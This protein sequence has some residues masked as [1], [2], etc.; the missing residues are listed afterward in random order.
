MPKRKVTITFDEDGEPQINDC[1]TS[2]YGDSNGRS[3]YVSINKKY[4]LK[5]DDRGFHHDDEGV[6]ARIA[7]N[8]RKYFVPTIAQGYTKNGDRWS[9]QEFL[10]LDNDVTEEAQEIV[11]DLVYRYDLHD[12]TSWESGYT[13]NWA[14]HNGQ[15]IIFDYSLGG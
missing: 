13:H 14:M 12:I 11:D 1:I 6:Y 15:P 2:H 4:I 5:I 9:V 8:D 3:V 10:E 7:E